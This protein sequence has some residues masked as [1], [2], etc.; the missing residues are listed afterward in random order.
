MR[1]KRKKERKK[2]NTFSNL[3]KFFEDQSRTDPETNAFDST[4]QP[5]LPDPPQQLPSV[6]IS[7]NVHCPFSSVS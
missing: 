2:A 6:L 3:Y 1:E 7:S 4:P 5:P